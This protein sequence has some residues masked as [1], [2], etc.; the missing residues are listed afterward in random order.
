[1]PPT[2]VKKGIIAQFALCRKTSRTGFCK[3]HQTACNI[4]RYVMHQLINERCPICK[5]AEERK[6]R[7]RAKKKKAYL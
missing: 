7:K 6:E 2:D 4:H 3:K 5:E 1:M